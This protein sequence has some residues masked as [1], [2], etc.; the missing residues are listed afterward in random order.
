MPLSDHRSESRPRA[1]PTQWV[2]RLVSRH[3]HSLLF[4]AILALGC[5]TRL[6]HI[7]SMP[8]WLDEVTTVR[9]SSLSFGAM[10]Q[11]SLMAHH[12]PSYFWIASLSGHYGLGEGVLRVPSAIFGGAS[13]AVLY[14]VGAR[15]GGWKAGLVAGL[16]LALSPLQVQYGQEARS[17]TF[18]MLMMAVGLWGLVEIARAPRATTLPFGSPGAR[19]AP[20]VIYTLGTLGALQVLSTAFFWL[21]S[22]NCAAFAIALD[23]SIDK[24][25]FWQR[26]LLSQAI[27]L[28]LTLPWFLAMTIVTRGQMGSGTDWVPAM[29]L[30]SFTSTLGSLYFMRISR[31]ISFHLFPVV[32]PGFGALLL[33]FGVLGV[34]H[35]RRRGASRLLGSVAPTM[36]RTL[37]IVA[38]VPPLLILLISI[39]KPL[40]MPRYLLWSAVPFFVFVGL[41]VAILPGQRLQLAAVSVIALLA[42]INLAPYYQSETKPRWDLAAHD[43]VNILQPGD[44]VLV[45][46]RGPIA[47]MDFFLARDGQA[48]PDSLWTRDI[49]KAAAYVHD[50]GRVWVVEGK[51]GQAD[52]TPAKSFNAIT[53]PLG[54]PIAVLPEGDLITF[55]LYDDLPD[56][57]L[58]AQGTGTPG[59]YP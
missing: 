50:G 10:V 39:G 5:V 56:K 14:L 12:L 59:L 51:V 19:L 7:G 46:D 6:Y 2:G 18:V 42:A 8:Y 29:T 35:L 26:W 28:G 57:S 53:A 13:A 43:L 49:F 15:A 24:R 54:S 41:G 45:P 17:Y 11:D 52:H 44:M 22:A 37:L 34:A 40:W 4:L 36:L 48:I 55:K 31:L 25:R 16:L 9:R 27:I 3:G 33:L 32:V 58:I 21:I 47:I 23:P 38:I 20:W 1:D 30:H